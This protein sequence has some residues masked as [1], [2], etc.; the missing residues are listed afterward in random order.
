MY[1]VLEQSE[2]PPAVSLWLGLTS[3]I[4][5]TRIRAGSLSRESGSV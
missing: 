2:I 3:L 1:N 4:A 5:I